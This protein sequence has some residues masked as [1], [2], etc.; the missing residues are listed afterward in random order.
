MQI[1]RGS[2]IARSMGRKVGEGEWKKEG[3][4]PSEKSDGG[5]KGRWTLETTSPRGRT[6]P[7]SRGFADVRTRGNRTRRGGAG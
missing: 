2:P 5:T 1:L 6:L 7:G 4:E 3:E